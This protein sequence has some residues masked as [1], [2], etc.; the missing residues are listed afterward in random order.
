MDR[1]GDI[2]PFVMKGLKVFKKNEADSI[3][4]NDQIEKVSK[5]FKF[6]SSSKVFSCTS[7]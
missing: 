2:I 3:K 6:S 5:L 1:G 7:A 4:K